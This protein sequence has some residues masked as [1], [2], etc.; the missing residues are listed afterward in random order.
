MQGIKKKSFLK[1]AQKT[2]LFGKTDAHRD[3]LKPSQK[4]RLV[5]RILWLFVAI[6][7]ATRKTLPDGFSEAFIG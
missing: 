5:D 3:T 2:S 1:N 6:R 4:I 7:E